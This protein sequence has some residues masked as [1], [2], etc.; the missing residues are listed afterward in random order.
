MKMISVFLWQGPMTGLKTLA[1]GSEALNPWG[2]KQKSEHHCRGWN[3]G[4]DINPEVSQKDESAV[5]LSAFKWENITGIL[6]HAKT[7][8]WAS[9]SSFC[10]ASEFYAQRNNDSVVASSW[11]SKTA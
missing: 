6:L 9:I 10:L 1:N 4:N 8:K 7:E 11:R 2:L 3:L 5:R